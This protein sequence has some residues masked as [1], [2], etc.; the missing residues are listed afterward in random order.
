MLKNNYEIIGK[1]NP[2]IVLKNEDKIFKIQTIGDPHLGRNYRNNLKSRLGEREEDIKNTFINLLNSDSDLVVIMGDLLDKVVV[3]NEWLDFTIRAFEDA[4]LNKQYIVLNGNHDEVKDKSRISSFRLIER[5]FNTYQKPNLS[6]VSDDVLF[7]E[8]P[9]FKTQ[10]CFTNYDSFKSLDEIYQDSSDLIEEGYEDYLKI[11][12][13]H[14]EV[15]SFGS[16]KFIDRL[17]P[18]ILLNNFDLIVT[19]HIHTPSFVR[20]EDTPILV[21]GSMQPYAFGENIPEDG[22]IYIDINIKELKEILDKDPNYFKYSNIRIHYDKGDDFLSSFD[23]YSFSYKLNNSL[24][25]K[26]EILKDIST[27]SFSSLFLDSLSQLKTTENEIY[28]NSLE[29]VFMEKD[30]ESN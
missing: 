9:F 5:Y 19:G 24:E 1:R 28:V 7:I 11:A 14:F 27:L 13:G 30:Y 4:P 6:F 26:K 22:N 29:R 25:K 16:N 10:L 2:I 3:T 18:K 8:K 23:C 12:F 15:E 17:I 21:T 20:V